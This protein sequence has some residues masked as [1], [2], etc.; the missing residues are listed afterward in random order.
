MKLIHIIGIIAATV[1][2]AAAPAA[3]QEL[4]LPAKITASTVQLQ[5]AGA[6]LPS[7][8]YDKWIAVYQHDHPTVRISYDAVGSGEGIKRFIAGTVDF[9]ASDSAMQDSEIAQVQRHCH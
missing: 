9:G 2:L 7:P 4:P 1:V 6:T 3:A 8:L 5:G